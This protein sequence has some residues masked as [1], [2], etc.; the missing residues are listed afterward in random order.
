MVYC[1][2]SAK[3][4][5]CPDPVWKPVRVESWNG[6]LAQRAGR[7]LHR[8]STRF[9]PCGRGPGCAGPSVGEG[10]APHEIVTVIVIVIMITSVTLVILLVIIIQLMMIQLI[11]I[12]LIIIITI[13][14]MTIRFRHRN[15]AWVR[16]ALRSVGLRGLAR[17]SY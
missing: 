17:Q 6:Y 15:W 2:T 13:I 5:A 10:S 12:L 14:I 3:K 11:V 16:G 9:V 7:P 8:T 4:N 1:G